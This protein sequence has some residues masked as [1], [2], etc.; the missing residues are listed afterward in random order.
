MLYSC[1]DLI[2][3]YRLLGQHQYN[4]RLHQPYKNLP[5][6]LIYL[7]IKTTISWFFFIQFIIHTKTIDGKILYKND[8]I[9]E[10][11]EQHTVQ[12][13]AV[14]TPRG[15]D[16][17]TVKPPTELRLVAGA[18]CVTVLDL[19]LP[20]TR[21]IV[22]TVTPATLPESS[23]MCLLCYDERFDTCILIRYC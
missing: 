8:K 17:G 10:S 12:Y 18:G 2:C 22:Q 4:R 7:M 11:I 9:L 21:C 14:H 13:C 15:E 16:R 20:E 19:C 23:K 1:Y 6:Y 5:K 3:Q